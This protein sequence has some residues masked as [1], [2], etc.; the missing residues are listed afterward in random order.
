MA[1]AKK[2]ETKLRRLREQAAELMSA[3]KYDRAVDIYEK[4]SRIDETNG[5]WARRA[6][7]C[8]WHLKNPDQR[9]K[10][11]LLAARAYSEEGLLLKAIAMCKVALSIDP[12]HRETLEELS[13]LH[14]RAPQGQS[15]ARVGGA[16]RRAVGAALGPGVTGEG[17]GVPAEAGST[18]RRNSLRPTTPEDEERKEERTRARMAAAAAL[19][20]ARAQKRKE[21]IAE[22]RKKR[23]VP[24]QASTLLDVRRNAEV[25]EAETGRV[26]TPDAK[27]TSAFAEAKSP[28]A[29][30]KVVARVALKPVIRTSGM[31]LTKENNPTTLP[32]P[33]RAEPFIPSLRVDPPPRNN[34]SPGLTSLRLSERVPARN[35]V[36]LPPA[37]G[38][39]YSLALADI[40]NA[41]LKA[42]RVPKIKLPPITSEDHFYVPVI[43]P[44]EDE[45][46]PSSVNS[47][48][49]FYVPIIPPPESE[50]PPDS[51]D[52]EDI[53]FGSALSSDR[54]D[55]A[56]KDFA[57]IPLLSD[58]PADVLRQ[59]ITDV[60]MVELQTNEVLFAEGDPADA[61]YVVVEGSVTAVT[62]PHREKP[63]Q[64][65]HLF[66]G[67]FFGEIGLM[68]DQ[69][70]GATVT[71]H[72]PTRLL[73]FDRDIVAVLIE[74]DPN[75]LATLLQFLKDRLV[76]DLMMSS[77][78][79]APFSKDE[80][81]DLADQFEFLEIEPDSIL[82]ER[83]QHPIGMYVLLTGEASMKGASEAG[84]L[85]R[86]GPGDIF[87]EQALLANEV[88]KVEVRT[89][90]KSFALCL[91]SDAFPE[92]IM[93]HPTILEYLS[94]L[95]E[96]SKGE[97]DVAEDFLDH[98]RFF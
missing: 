36:S 1:A 46:P 53:S 92:V 38:N 4:L 51:V 7:D 68:S 52:T 49:H 94:T 98:V 10:Y 74:Q 33:P 37:P 22:V 83:G 28:R 20:Q 54:G 65:A 24:E 56:N 76:E 6:A 60:A 40:S 69:P 62:L 18:R 27:E 77:P 73:R 2:V 17:Q 96:S 59:L 80:R 50:P 64:L 14:S 43:P 29:R 13:R 26:L 47:E 31:P 21:D 8:H 95:S 90:T 30:D 12:H 93:S 45:P 63:I 84:T 97:L 58:L 41:E 89:S 19:R 16:P 35:L 88:S 55:V 9:L 39:V 3:E 86:L 79:F 23:E 91:P 32:R 78:L 85:R 34:N 67:D 57:G 5:E 72:E 48:D 15:R 61:M 81:Y 87:G 75:F 11:S 70:R 25:T 71:A 82:L 66:E 44:P 42:F